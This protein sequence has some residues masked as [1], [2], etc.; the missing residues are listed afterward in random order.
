MQGQQNTGVQRVFLL[1]LIIKIQYRRNNGC[2]KVLLAFCSI[3]LRNY[4]FARFTRNKPQQCHMVVG[5]RRYMYPPS[6]EQKLFEEMKDTVVFCFETYNE[7]SQW[8]ACTSCLLVSYI[9]RNGAHNL[10]A[11]H[12]V[13]TE[14]CLMEERL[15]SED[16]QDMQVEEVSNGVITKI[17]DIQ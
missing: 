10:L 2:T 7:S 11:I 17:N 5:S 13:S 3:K 8:K 16:I 4:I 1:L 9:T 12:N 14:S 15:S 6:K